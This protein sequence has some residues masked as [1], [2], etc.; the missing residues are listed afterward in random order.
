M[1]I[2]IDRRPAP[3]SNAERQ[4]QWRQRRKEKRA[5]ALRVTEVGP[6]RAVVTRNAVAPAP[7]TAD[8]L[9][10]QLTK[11]HQRGNQ[12]VAEYVALLATP[13][14]TLAEAQ[15]ISARFL[16]WR[17]L[18]DGVA[19]ISHR[20]LPVKTGQTLPSTVLKWR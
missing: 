4:R 3:L 11:L 12:L 13:G 18:F 19:K 5:A 17:R 15:T 6:D 20:R 7:V 9:D 10:D 1:G 2:T 16:Y 14:L 8:T